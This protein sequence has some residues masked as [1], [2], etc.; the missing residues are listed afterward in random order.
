MDSPTIRVATADDAAALS[1]LLGQ[2]GYPCEPSDIPGRLSEMMARP[3][4]VVL[5]A[6]HQGVAVGVLTVHL[7]PALHATEPTAWLT[8]VVV[9]EKFRGRGVGAALLRYAE[10]WA[11]Q[12]G[13]QRVSLT[14]ALR[15]TRAHEFYKTHGYE[16]TG[17]RLA[18]VLADNASGPRGN[19]SERSTPTGRPE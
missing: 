13:A 3:G 18:K 6:D 8:A 7:F 4:T 11:R 1:D 5:I 15:R 10:E 9:D 14:S 16:Q 2:L 17:V 19:A 12:R